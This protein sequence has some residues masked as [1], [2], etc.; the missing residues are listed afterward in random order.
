MGEARGER[1]WGRGDGIGVE[2]ADGG[3][4]ARGEEAFGGALV[5]LASW[6]VEEAAAGFAAGGG[7]GAGSLAS[8]S[9]ENGVAG[10]PAWGG[11]CARAWDA[12]GPWAWVA[13]DDATVDTGIRTSIR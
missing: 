5:S 10:A 4:G 7:G 1:S 12:C 11:R 9:A 6:A 3:E 13:V 2:I 8:I